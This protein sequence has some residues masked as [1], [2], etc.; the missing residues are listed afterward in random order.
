MTE[1]NKILKRHVI[2][3][4]GPSE[5]FIEGALLG[6]GA[7]GCVVTTRPDALHLFFGHN[8]VWDRRVPEVPDSEDNTFEKVMEKLRAVPEDLS[9]LMDDPWF[10]EHFDYNFSR[11]GEV[12]PRPFPCGSVVFGFDRRDT[13]VLG[14]RLSLGEGLLTVELLHCARVVEVKIFLE[15]GCDRVWIQSVCELGEPTANPFTRVVVY[16]DTTTVGDFP[17]DNSLADATHGKLGFRQK[18]ESCEADPDRSGAFHRYFVELEMVTSSAL[19]DRRI[20]LNTNHE[21]RYQNAVEPD[22]QKFTEQTQPLEKYFATTAPLVACINLR[23]GRVSECSEECSVNE[24]LQTTEILDKELEKALEGSRE[25]WATFWNASSIEIADEFLEGVW[26]RNQYFLNCVLKPGTTCPGIFGNWMSGNIGTSWH[27]DYHMNYNTQQLFWG[28]FSSNHLEKHLPYIELIEDYLLPIAEGWAKD[29]YGMRGASFPYCAV[30]V[31]MEKPLLLGAD[32]SWGVG[33]SAWIVQ[34]LWWHYAYSG[35]RELLSKRVFP[36]LESTVTFVVD[37]LS[38][39]D[40]CGG[41]RADDCIH[42]FPSLSQELYRLR[43][44]FLANEDSIIDLT[45]VRCLLRIYAEA[46]ALVADPDPSLLQRSKEILAKLAPY[47]TAQTKEGDVFVSVPGESADVVHNAPQ[48]LMPVFPAEEIGLGSDSEAIARARRTYRFHRNEGGNDLVFNNLQG[49]RLGVLDLERFK[50]QIRYCLLPNGTCTDMNLI[51]GGRHG[52]L[53]SFSFMKRM[54]IWVE[55]F[56]LPVVINECLMQSYDG[57]LRL[58]P[59]W[60]KGHASF[61]N[62]RAVGGFLVSADYDGESVKNLRVQS[63]TSRDN[64]LSLINPWESAEWLRADGAKEKSTESLIEVSLKAQE[65]IE[66]G[67]SGIE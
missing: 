40:C 45:M 27:G 35:D 43:P 7:T 8:D 13:E 58:F 37:F 5:D 51:A 44:G 53:H 67:Q 18:M 42:I 19:E 2:C 52:D 62:L 9:H 17:A 12:Y 39:A 1:T 47:P 20:P 61:E 11:Y 15:W 4:E 6:N 25:E 14:H 22:L 29:Y 24:R 48:P 26:Y 66:F 21:L 57:C 31:K 23:Q 32:W 64:R 33:I 16:P 59:N 60:T 10:K 50:R 36:V 63:D 56:S 38:R 54:G 49:A 55:N 34:S 30:P 46:A 28:T 3:R 65:T 41:S